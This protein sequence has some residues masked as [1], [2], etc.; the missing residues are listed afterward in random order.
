MIK[1]QNHQVRPDRRTKDAYLMGA[2]GDVK[3][4]LFDFGGVIAEEGFKQGLHAIATDNGLDPDIVISTAFEI[5]YDIGFV[6][7]KV[8]ENA[9]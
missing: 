7:G 2:T 6:L 3:A 8:R 5:N 4:V 9:F 1:G